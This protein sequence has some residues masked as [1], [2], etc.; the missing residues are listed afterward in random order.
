[1]IDGIG[2]RSIYDGVVLLL[3]DGPQVPVGV[4]PDLPYAT[5][6]LEPQVDNATMTI[7]HDKHFNAYVTALPALVGNNSQLQ[8]LSLAE[9]QRQAGTGIVSGAFAKTLQNSG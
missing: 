4:L 7:H 1:M 8:G 9:L 5:D 6:A 2:L 3:Q